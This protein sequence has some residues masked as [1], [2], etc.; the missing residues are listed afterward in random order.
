MRHLYIVYETDD[1]GNCDPSKRRGVF[2]S[3]RAAVEAIVGHI[4]IV[5]G[6]FFCSSVVKQ[7]SE[8]S[9]VASAKRRIRKVL[10]KAGVVVILSKHLGYAIVEVEA[11]DWDAD[12]CNRNAPKRNHDD[13]G[14]GDSIF[15]H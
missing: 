5:V 4:D 6:E 9:L 15:I 13:E 12:Y 7:Y 14:E 3:R 10:N 1:W 11:N 8:R 2:T